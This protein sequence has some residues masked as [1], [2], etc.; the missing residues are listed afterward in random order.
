MVSLRAVALTA[1]AVAALTSAASAADRLPPPPAMEAPPPAFSEGSSGWYL[2]GDVGVGVNSSSGFSSNASIAPGFTNEYYNNNL[3]ESAIIDAGVGYQ[4][5]SWFRG[6]VTGELRGGSEF[7]GLQV[8]N[9]TSA[10]AAT[11]TGYSQFADSY[12]G[13]LSSAIV[14]AN[15]Y[16][17]AGTYFG[18]TPYFGGGLGVAFNKFSGGSDIGANTNYLGPTTGSGGVI[19][20]GTKA[21]L[22]WDLAAGID[23]SITHQLKL[24]L[25]YRYLNYGSFKSGTSQCL[26]GN[27]PLGTG[28]F[29]CSGNTYQ[30]ASR[31]L[32]ANDFHIGLRYY[33]DSPAPAPQYDAP[34]VRKY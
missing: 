28:S 31:N 26:S 10:A 21:N 23:V 8:S 2:R 30:L 12:R 15:A 9:A 11:S 17:D 34:L 14:L 19:P 7:S 25:G 5:N 29:S 4:V 33:L 6:D 16:I 22:A 3:S 20:S 32:S 27:V 13:N 1:V 18:V 24:E